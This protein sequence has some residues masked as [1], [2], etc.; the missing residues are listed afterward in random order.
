MEAPFVREADAA[1][2]SFFAFH[3]P[4]ALLTAFRDSGVTPLPYVA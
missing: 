4:P 3:S 2:A 1:K